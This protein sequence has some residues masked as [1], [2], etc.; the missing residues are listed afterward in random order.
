MLKFFQII[1]LLFLVF[2]VD[3]L[4]QCMDEATYCTTRDAFIAL[5]FIVII[6]WSIYFI[7]KQK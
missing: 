5:M 4:F 7:Y 1:T 3:R 6:P 2:W